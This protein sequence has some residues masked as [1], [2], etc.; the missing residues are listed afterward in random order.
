[1]T[2]DTPK[3]WRDLNPVSNTAHSALPEAMASSEYKTMVQCTP[4]LVAGIAKDPKEMAD[5]L[6]SKG[7]IAERVQGEMSLQLTAADKARKL[8]E[9]VTSKVKIYP[10]KPSVTFW[11]FSGI[12]DGLKY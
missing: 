2:L 11:I 3:A 7:L 9:N 8:V 4:K 10:K 5:A 1:M 6:F 12:V